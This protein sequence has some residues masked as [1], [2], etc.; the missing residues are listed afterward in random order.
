MPRLGSLSI[1]GDDGGGESTAGSGDRNDFPL[2]RV[3]RPT[4]IEQD[5]RMQRRPGGT[6]NEGPTRGVLLWLVGIPLLNNLLSY[7][8]GVP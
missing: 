8:F 5:C 6:P 4:A 1:F 3:L 2:S 7:L